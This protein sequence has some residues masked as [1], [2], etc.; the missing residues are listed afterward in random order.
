MPIWAF[1]APHYEM[2]PAQE[3]VAADQYDM[4][5]HPPLS[6]GAMANAVRTPWFTIRGDTAFAPSSAGYVDIDDLES[7]DQ[8]LERLAIEA[9]LTPD[10]V[11]VVFY[12]PFLWEM[13]GR[14]DDLKRL[15]DGI[16]ALGYRFVSACETVT[17]LRL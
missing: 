5:H 9:T 15:I 11:A 12:H 17:E 2:S 16:E 7:T 6:H 8:I 13:P 1:E 4:I 3:A 10:P 14:E